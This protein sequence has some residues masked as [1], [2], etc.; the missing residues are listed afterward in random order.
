MISMVDES[1]ETLLCVS[2]HA[3]KRISQGTVQFS[4]SCSE[5]LLIHRSCIH[6][7]DVCSSILFEATELQ[8][9]YAAIH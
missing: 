8:K 5:D 4:T 3:K 7:Q 1:S 2:K 6:L 9:L